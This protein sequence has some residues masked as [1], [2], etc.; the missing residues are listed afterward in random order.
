MKPK[1]NNGHGGYRKGAGRKPGDP[2]QHKRALNTKVSFLCHQQ[3]TTLMQRFNLNKA[4]TIERIVA[5]A[6]AKSVAEPAT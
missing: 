5:E 3:L 6:C 4:L 2:T 1:P